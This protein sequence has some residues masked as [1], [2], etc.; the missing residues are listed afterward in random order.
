MIADLPTLLSR[1]AEKRRNRDDMTRKNR[2]RRVRLLIAR[3]DV[4]LA[5]NLFERLLDPQAGHAVAP[6]IAF[7]RSGVRRMPERDA[8]GRRWLNVGTGDILER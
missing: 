2:C 4:M 5:K 1:H 7:R 8:A 3:R 6:R